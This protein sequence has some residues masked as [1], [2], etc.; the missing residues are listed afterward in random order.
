MKKDV[1][2]DETCWNF[3]HYARACGHFGYEPP[4]ENK[5]NAISET[6]K[7]W[8]KEYRKNKKT[9]LASHPNCEAMLK[10]CGKK[11][12]DVH[13]KKGRQTRDHYV[14]PQ[15]FL[16]VCRNCHDII[17]RNPEFAKAFGFSE[18]RL[19]KPTK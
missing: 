3:D 15:Y 7:E 8:E 10:G 11:S 19:S 14:N 4:K 16:A 13:H 17:E 12:V 1:C 5:I 6:R 18:S 9:F 2:K